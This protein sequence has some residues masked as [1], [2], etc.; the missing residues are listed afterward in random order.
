MSRVFPLSF[1]V[2][3]FVAA[4]LALAGV[5]HGGGTAQADAPPPSYTKVSMPD[6]GQ[7]STGW[8]WVGAAADSFW[9]YAHNTTGEDGLL[10]GVGHPWEATDPNSQTPGS[11]CQGGATSWYDAN[12]IPQGPPPAG[13]IPGYRQLLSKI[14]QTTFKDANQNGIKDGGENNYCYSEGVEKWDYLIGLRDFVKNYGSALKVHDIIDPARCGV[15]VGMLPTRQFPP[16]FNTRNACGPGNR[17]VPGVDQ[18]VLPPTFLDYQTELSRSQDVLMWMEST[19]PETAHVVTG[20]GYDTAPN[21][22]T[23]T[24][25]DPWTHSTCADH[26]DCWPLNPLPNGLMPDHNNAPGHAV[27][28]YN[29]CTVVNPGPAPKFTINCGGTV[30][31]VY[32]MIF[33]SPIEIDPFPNSLAK[34]DVHSALGDETVT[35]TGPTTVEVDLASLVPADPPALERLETEIVS[36]QLTGHSPKLGSVTLRL[37]DPAKRPFHRT[38]GEIEENLNVQKGRLDLLGDNAPL[39]VEH[40]SPPLNCMNTTADSFFDVYFE[41]EVSAL[42]GLVMH[43]EIPKH[44]EETITHKPPAS[45]E[46]YENPDHIPLLDEDGNPTGVEIRATFHTPCPYVPVGGIAELP[47]AAGSSGPPYALLAGALAA[48]LALGAGAWYARRRW[49]R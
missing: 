17:G 36:M 42:P 16:T 30:W 28:P 10:G 43:N 38:V 19:T 49:V 29:I 14:A 39:C 46:T 2:L 24:I 32:D 37:R 40:P 26:D 20:V 25:S 6:F 22:D 23:I 41:V 9:W 5:L 4:T 44:M 13:P 48:V 47:D 33:V 45:G 15:G 21:P 27:G 1:S 7:H 8:C 18:V 34:V 31:T 3:L 11:A 35:L 12:D